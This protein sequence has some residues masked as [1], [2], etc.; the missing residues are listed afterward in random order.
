[1][2]AGHRKRVASMKFSRNAFPYPVG[3]GQGPFLA[4]IG[5]ERADCIPLAVGRGS[6]LQ[7]SN[8]RDQVFQ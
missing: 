7:N 5:G 2:A 8:E 3:K 6:S 1:M 4:L